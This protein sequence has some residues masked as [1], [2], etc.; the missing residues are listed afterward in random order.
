MTKLVNYFVHLIVKFF[1]CLLIW[2]K[3]ALYF[4]LIKKLSISNF[5]Y[6]FEGL[7][8]YINE[9]NDIS[10]KYIAGGMYMGSYQEMLSDENKKFCFIDIGSNMGYFSIKAGKNKNCYKVFSIEPNKIISKVLRKNL[11]HNITSK[12]EI[13]NLAISKENKISKFYINKTHSGTSSL[14]SN[15]DKKN[16]PIMVK[17]QNYKFLN[18][19]NKQIPEDIKIFVKIDTEGNDIEILKEIKKSKIFDKISNVYIETKNKKKDILKIKKILRS[20]HSY[21]THSILENIS[22]KKLINLELIKND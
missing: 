1:V 18:K 20:F 15:S 21:K 12:F 19:L 9:I 13:F 4:F 7:K 2:K 11:K 14:H 10:L 3:K 16:I 17:T 5:L 6:S 8:L 22:K